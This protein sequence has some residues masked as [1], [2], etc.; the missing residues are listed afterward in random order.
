MLSVIISVPIYNYN[1]DKHNRKLKGE[2]KT[3]YIKY[4]YYLFK[5]ITNVDRPP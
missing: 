3:K 4:T 1:P 5:L 2:H